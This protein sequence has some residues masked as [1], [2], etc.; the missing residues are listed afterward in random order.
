V[1]SR[2]LVA[3]AGCIVL[4]LLG[5]CGTGGGHDAPTGSPLDPER[6]VALKAAHREQQTI[7]GTFL[8]ATYQPDAG[9]IASSNTG[10]PCTP[11]HTLL[12]RL[13][14]KDDASFVHGGTVG[15]PP[16]G[17]HKALLLTVNVP[18]GEICL[19]GA[20]YAHDDPKPGEIY[21]YGS[22]KDLVSSR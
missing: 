2:R 18:S 19:V 15:G 7:T 16:D 6:A 3:A 9:E 1:V 12:I 8:V 10:H 14:W 22:R 17:R 21:L 20:S 11:G 4:V 5:G 13:L